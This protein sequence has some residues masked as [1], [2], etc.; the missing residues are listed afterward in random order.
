MKSSAS[1]CA[2]LRIKHLG[3]E[4]DDLLDTNQ[5]ALQT[6]TLPD[7]RIRVGSTTVCPNVVRT[8]HWAMSRR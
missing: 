7:G 4:A 5:L 3:V 6:F 2:E 8:P 1:K